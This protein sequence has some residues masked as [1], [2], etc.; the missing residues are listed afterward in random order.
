MYNNEL[1]SEY[2]NKTELAKKI[3]NDQTEIAANGMSQMEVDKTK[4]AA[5]KQRKRKRV[6]K[7][8]HS[9]LFTDESAWD[10]LSSD[11]DSGEE[12]EEEASDGKNRCKPPDKTKKI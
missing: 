2:G 12:T 1:N 3:V 7:M 5:E 11:T 6:I 9:L 10:N 4:V 8:P